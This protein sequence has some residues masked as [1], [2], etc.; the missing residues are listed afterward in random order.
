MD[1]DLYVINGKVA[2]L[3]SLLNGNRP[4]AEECHLTP[5]DFGQI[6]EELYQE[7]YLMRTN[8]GNVL[9]AEVSDKGMSYLHTITETL[10]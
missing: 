1:E 6:C 10:S 4:S 7:G 3:S 9:N 5:E 2:I 8:L